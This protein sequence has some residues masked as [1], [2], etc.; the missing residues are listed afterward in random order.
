M[1]EAQDAWELALILLASQL[2]HSTFETWVKPLYVSGVA[3]NRL[4]LR[5][6]GR[7]APWARRRY[8]ELIDRAIRETSQYEGVTSNDT[9]Y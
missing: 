5:G 8:G 6:P 1:K 9:R 7:V 4:V 3:G 2:P